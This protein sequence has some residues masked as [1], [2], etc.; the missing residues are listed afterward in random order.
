MSVLDMPC[1][2]M[3]NHNRVFQVWLVSG[4][5]MAVDNFLFVVKVM[6]QC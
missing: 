5:I 6:E 3:K 2:T 4:K 1:K